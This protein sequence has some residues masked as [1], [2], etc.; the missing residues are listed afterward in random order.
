MTYNFRNRNQNVSYVEASDEENDFCTMIESLTPLPASQTNHH[1]NGRRRGRRPNRPNRNAD[2]NALRW[3][4]RH[5][6]ASKS[7]RPRMVLPTF[8]INERRYV[9]ETRTSLEPSRMIEI[10]ESL[11]ITNYVP[12]SNNTLEQNLTMETDL[13][14]INE[15]RNAGVQEMSNNQDQNM[16]MAANSPFRNQATNDNQEQNVMIEPDHPSLIP[17]PIQRATTET[18][19]QQQENTTLSKKTI[20]AWLTACK[21]IDEGGQVRYKGG[22]KTITGRISNGAIICSCCDQEFSVW[23]FEKHNKSTQ[24]QPYKNIFMTRHNRLLE[25]SIIGAWMSAEEQNRRS[26]FS[27]VCNEE[28]TLYSCLVCGDGTEREP[29]FCDKCPST[30]H[31]SCANMQVINFVFLPMFTTKF[32]IVDEKISNCQMFFYVFILQNVRFCEDWLCHYCRCK[33]CEV[34]EENEHLVTCCHCLKKCKFSLVIFT[35]LFF[36]T[37]IH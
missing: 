15:R 28:Q 22:V 33:F 12:E 36:M 29:I 9:P 23:E 13:S 30:Y 35:F 4:N 19:S 16:M 6:R 24:Q 2:I 27:Y 5:M 7:R 1:G 10:D 17:E 8:Q 21:A 25:Q 32:E 14:S 37:K 26:M 3:R 11:N 34:G 31:K 20:L 18:S